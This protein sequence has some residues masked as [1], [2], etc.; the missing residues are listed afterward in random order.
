MSYFDGDKLKD[1]WKL[2]EDG[3]LSLLNSYSC[4]NAYSSE[5]DFDACYAE[6][7]IVA[8]TGFGFTT[9]NYKLLSVDDNTYI[10]QYGLRAKYAVEDWAYESI[11]RFE[12]LDK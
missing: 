11:R 5:L 3:S 6:A 8:L 1:F 2:E 10:F 9:R 7:K 12:K 4:P